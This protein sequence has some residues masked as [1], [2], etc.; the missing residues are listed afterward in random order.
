MMSNLEMKLS[1]HF[2]LGELIRTSH[3]GVDNYP[4]EAILAELIDLCENFLEPIRDEFGPL[5]VSS[6][7][8]S[9]ELNTLVGGSKSSAHMF[10]CAADFVP[11][12]NKYTTKDIV[13]WIKDSDLDFDQVIDEYGNSTSN[14]VHI[15]KTKPPKKLQPRYE[16]LTFKDGKYSKFV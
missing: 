9:K 10:G 2:K 3:R 6:G 12:K 4:N 15:G 1:A 13:R 5:I 11:Y 14:W 7:Y 8:R 16:A